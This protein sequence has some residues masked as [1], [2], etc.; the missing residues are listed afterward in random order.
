MLVN[1]SANIPKIKIFGITN[2]EDA[3]IGVEAGVDVLGFVFYP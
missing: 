3:A 2:V 1:S